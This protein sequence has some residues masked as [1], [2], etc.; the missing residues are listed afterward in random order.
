MVS[1]ISWIRS[2]LQSSVDGI[3]CV[4]CRARQTVRQVEIKE[5]QTS[6]RLVR[7]LIGECRVC[8][9]PTATFVS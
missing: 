7:L 9:G 6:K 2:R 8:C 4:H 5:V 3:W 1:L